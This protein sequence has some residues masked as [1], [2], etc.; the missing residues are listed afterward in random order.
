MNFQS[1]YQNPLNSMHYQLQNL[2]LQ[3][4]APLDPAI[5]QIGTPV[6]PAQPLSRTA[7]LMDSIG[8]QRSSSPF[9]DPASGLNTGHMLKPIAHKHHP[10]HPHPQ[11]SASSSPYP[12]Q[13]A[14]PNI[15]HGGLFTG[16]ASMAPPGVAAAPTVP[17]LVVESQWRYID[18]Q[19]Q[20][21]GPFGSGPMSQWYASG[22]FQPSL[23]VS[24]VGTSLEPFGINDRF[25][26][27]GELI[28]KANNFQDPFHAFD[29]IA[30]SMLSGMGSSF[31]GSP[32]QQQFQIQQQQEQESK[33]PLGSADYT[34]DEILQ[35]RDPD[36]GYYR[37]VV[38]QVPT[39]ARKQERIEDRSIQ[40]RLEHK[41]KE[42]QRRRKEEEIGRIQRAEVAA[43]QTLQ[44]ESE[45]KKKD[46]ALQQEHEL[47]EIAQ[48]IVQ[49]APKANPEETIETAVRENIKETPKETPKA[50]PKEISNETL[51]ELSKETS[52]SGPKTT[53]KTSSKASPKASPKANQKTSKTASKTSAKEN[54]Q[55]Q[56]EAA[57]HKASPQA[58]EVKTSIA[59]WADK[60]KNAEM[61][62]IPSITEL[63]KKEEQER[64]EREL[65]E[66]VAADRL[67]QQ[68][69]KEDKERQGLKSV[70]TWADKPK[71]VPVNSVNIKPQVKKEEKK[72][73]SQIKGAV[74]LEEFNDPTFLKEQAKL[75][76]EAQKSKSRRTATPSAASGSSSASNA[77]T[78]VT[79]KSVKQ[80]TTNQQKPTVQPKSYISPDKLR[81]IGASSGPNKQIGSSTSI[82]GLKNT[83]GARAPTYPG[84]ASISARQVFLRW[85]RS[86]MK[87]NA[88]V[89]TDAV[90]EVLLSLPAGN[91]SIGIITDTINSNS[92]AMD[93]KRFAEE[94]IKRRQECE[95]HIED[96]LTWAEVLSMPE[97]DDDDWEFQVVSK[98]KGRKH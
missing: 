81:A 51:N 61:P 7:S 68:I 18:T 13:V 88:S 58:Q 93:G 73:P 9:V 60:V 79:S 53:S 3:N 75:W 12:S 63:Q 72:K 86:H 29:L 22:Y 52:K 35:L 64:A 16:P 24:R 34:H 55:G 87:L 26:S 36:G 57:K 56:E 19:G 17:P 80:V 27:L 30:S 48:H 50:S 54:S 15:L 90:L 44:R 45:L 47:Q 41:K 14:T 2:S 25:M 85:C 94:F 42:D 37:D 74:P 71:P 82:P 84:N 28:S 77:W 43:K 69:I 8:I 65:Q 76:E 62:K 92:N 78:T 95:Q 5:S 49:A 11:D 40:A 6:L 89:R 1:Q 67:K 97:G 38:V 96:P 21:Q 83:Q 39:G 31:G 23:Q 33:K 10:H 70:L 59:P 46:V 91:E 32:E 98:K 4:G 20:I 66:R